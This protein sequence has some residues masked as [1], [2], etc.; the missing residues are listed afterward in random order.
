MHSAFASSLTVLCTLLLIAAC[1]GSDS[2]ETPDA[3][4]SHADAGHAQS[5]P[6]HDAGSTLHDAG[7]T[8]QDAGKLPSTMNTHP[9]L[10]AGK[11]HDAGMEAAVHDAA[12]PKDAG[13]SQDAAAV[14]CPSAF[15]EDFESGA[16][17][18]KIWTRK[19]T[20]TGN[21]VQVQTGK[22]AHGKYAAQFHIKAGGQRSMILLENL[23]AALQ[24]HYFGRMYFY[25][26]DFPTE[27]GGHTAYVTSSNTLKNFP[28]TDH[29]LEVASHVGSEDSWQLTY[30]TGD[31][32][33]YIGGGGVFPKAQWFCL[34]WEFNDAPDEIAVWVDGQGDP[35]GAEFRNINNHS[36]GLLGKMT[37]LGVGF[38]T[39]HPMG[40]PDI[41]IYVDD[42]QL[43][44]K[45]VG[46]I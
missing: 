19:E 42:I 24:Q 22:V 2:S 17:D 27:N 12:T 34:E 3:A 32:P 8:S 30:W 14:S 29:H 38:R 26:S 23:P 36:T 7:N 21:T 18:S 20:T 35:K 4:A 10:D 41:D 44:T 11:P 31:G 1:H 25:A 33:E 46:C 39:W 28:D 9:V 6:A 13:T 5:T 45:R 40:A 15:C 43:D 37:T 16:V